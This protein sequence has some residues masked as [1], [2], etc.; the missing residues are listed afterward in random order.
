MAVFKEYDHPDLFITFTCNLKWEEIQAAVRS[1]GFHDAS[2]R[3]DLVAWVFKMKLDAMIADFTK[4]R[5]LGRIIAGIF[6]IVFYCLII[7]L[8][9]VIIFDM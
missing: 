1:T 4:H 3:L 9:L 5:V 8:E 2:V 6:F 7:V